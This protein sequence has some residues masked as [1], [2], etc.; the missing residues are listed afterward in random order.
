[1]WSECSDCDGEDIKLMENV[2]VVNLSARKQ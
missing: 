2:N 1:M